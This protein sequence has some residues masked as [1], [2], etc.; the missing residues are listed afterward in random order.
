MYLCKN[1]QPK[2]QIIMYSE[3]IEGLIDAILADG[4]ISEKELTMLRRVAGEEGYD[5]DEVEIIAEGRLAK[6]KKSEA[7]AR[8][9][10]QAAATP[11]PP[12]PISAPNVAPRSSKYGEIRKCPNCGAVVES[13][14][15]KCADC[16]YA[17]V[18]IEALS[19]VQRFS[20]MI[21]KIEE[22]CASSG[23]GNLI[24]SGFASLYGLDSRTRKLASAIST[25]P[26]PNT[27]EDLMEFIMYLKPQQSLSSSPSDSKISLAYR[28]KYKEC[29]K[30]AKIFFPNDPQILAAIGEEK[31]GFFGKFFG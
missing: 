30:K 12:P 20:N 23:S 17:F 4:E 9:K 7:E 31:K 21:N 11:P 14:S 2:I 5:P 28:A 15:V 19:S 10:A 24:V 27:K 25:F 26:V 22:E 6:L 16:S 1:Q 8:L 13:G 18:G 3:R 29:I